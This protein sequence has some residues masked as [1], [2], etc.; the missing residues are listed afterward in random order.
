MAPILGELVERFAFGA[1][2]DVASDLLDGPFRPLPPA[3]AIGF[4]MDGVGDRIRQGEPAVGFDHGFGRWP[5]GGL[6]KLLIEL[7]S[8]LP[9]RRPGLGLGD[10]LEV[11]AD[12]PSTYCAVRC[13]SVNRPPK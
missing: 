10:V 11:L 6:A 3:L 12:R 1:G 4:T 9:G 2:P 8:L 13:M 5:G 7:G